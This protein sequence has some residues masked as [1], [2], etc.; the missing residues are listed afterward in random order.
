MSKHKKRVNIGQRAAETPDLRPTQPQTTAP[1]QEQPVADDQPPSEPD[2]SD[3]EAQEAQDDTAAE[4][5]PGIERH[6]LFW[7]VL[8]ALTVGIIVLLGIIL[9]GTGS[10]SPAARTTPTASSGVRPSTATSATGPAAQPDVNATITALVRANESVTRIEIA[11]AKRKMDAGEIIMVDVR[12]PG[13]YNEQHIK[14]A[15]NIPVD[16]TESRLAELPKDKEIVLYCA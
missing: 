6:P 15:I 8:G 12:Y 13:S 11:E 16:E 9:M 4:A 2:E 14:G 1:R 7:F 10:A 5:P 3:V